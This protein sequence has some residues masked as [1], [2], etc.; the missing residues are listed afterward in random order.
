MPDYEQTELI[1]I[2]GLWKKTSKNG[3]DYLS[4]KLRS[5]VRLNEGEMLMVFKN[6]NK[7]TDTQPDWNLYVKRKLDTQKP[8]LTEGEMKSADSTPSQEEIP[9]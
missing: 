2:T 5:T 3:K 4:A 6:T 1:S 8:L 9:F 7:K